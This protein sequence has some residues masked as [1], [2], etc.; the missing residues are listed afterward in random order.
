M[1]HLPGYYAGFGQRF[2]SAY[3]VNRI[4]YFAEHCLDLL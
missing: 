3:F 2:Y 4:V 1:Q